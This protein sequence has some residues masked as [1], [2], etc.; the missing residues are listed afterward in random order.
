MEFPGVDMRE[1]VPTPMRALPAG[2][3]F[4][5]HIGVVGRLRL[6]EAIEIVGGR[7]SAL[8]FHSGWTLEISAVKIR[9]F[10]MAQR[11]HSWGGEST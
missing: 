10:G 2:T 5:Q 8:R 3:Q 9:C 1:N 11:H 7:S 4:G 6:D